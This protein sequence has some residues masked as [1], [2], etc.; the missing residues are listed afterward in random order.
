MNQNVTNSRHMECVVL[1]SDPVPEIR[2]RKKA[3]LYRRQ[4]IMGKL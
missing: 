4:Y 1:M 2:F 3:L